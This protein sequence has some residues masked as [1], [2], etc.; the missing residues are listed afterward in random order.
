MGAGITITATAGA[1]AAARQPAVSQVS[2]QGGGHG[3]E[4]WSTRENFI[5]GW[6]SGEHC[7]SAV[8]QAKSVVGATHDFP[9]R[10]GDR[11]WFG[12]GL[13]VCL[14]VVP[15]CLVEAQGRHV[16]Y[17]PRSVAALRVS[18][19]V[20]WAACPAEMPYGT[21][22]RHG[23]CQTLP[24][25]PNAP[26]MATISRTM[27]GAGCVQPRV[28]R[29]G[30]RVRPR[31]VAGALP[32]AGGGA[33][34]QPHGGGRVVLQQVGTR[35][36]LQQVGER[37]REAPRV[38]YDSDGVWAGGLEGIGAVVR[39]GSRDTGLIQAWIVR[40][41]CRGCRGLTRLQGLQGL[42]AAAVPP[43]DVTTVRF[44]HGTVSG[45]T[46]TPLVHQGSRFCCFPASRLACLVRLAAPPL[47]H[48]SCPAAHSQHH[49][50]QPAPQPHAHSQHHNPAPAPQ[51]AT[52][53]SAPPPRWQRLRSLDRAAALQ[54]NVRVV[55]PQPVELLAGLV[56][57]L[58]NSQVG[59]G[60]HV[61]RW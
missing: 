39:G 3:A 61:A 10:E 25:Y 31:A 32:P 11:G 8:A 35:V 49:N 29:V 54:R 16:G 45:A 37:S 50:P 46:L 5:V 21:A 4:F 57:G 20:S 60:R 13:A 56:D 27:Y 30:P 23:Q 26:A 47:A 55:K 12:T 38:V 14:P 9:F 1:V 7:S 22:Y 34:G 6:R 51:P 40:R 19:W 2:G 48:A 43:A 15:C 17:L 59:A 36:V 42:D 18:P 52:R 58:Y 33:G 53:C 41:G 24:T 28:R 44:E